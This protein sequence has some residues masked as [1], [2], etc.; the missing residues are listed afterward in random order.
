[1]LKHRNVV[2]TKGHVFGNTSLMVTSICKDV[3]FLFLFMEI[4]ETADVFPRMQRCHV[5]IYL[6]WYLCVFKCFRAN[7]QLCGLEPFWFH[8]CNVGL[9]AAASLLFTRVCLA[10]AGLTP[11]FAA[12]AGALFA[13]HPIHTE[14]VSSNITN[15]VS[16]VVKRI[17]VIVLK[18]SLT[19]TW[20]FKIKITIRW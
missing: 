10:V 16:V 9:H 5:V 1:M 3:M 15:N 19:L 8:L 7:W 12:T 20:L 6:T 2:A 18:N 4:K 13:A 11:H 14:A 17:K